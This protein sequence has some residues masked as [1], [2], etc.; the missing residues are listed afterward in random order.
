MTNNTIQDKLSFFALEGTREVIHENRMFNNRR[1]RPSTPR[2]ANG[3]KAN[4]VLEVKKSIQL[5]LF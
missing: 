3:I 5:S 4:N 1:R 2:N